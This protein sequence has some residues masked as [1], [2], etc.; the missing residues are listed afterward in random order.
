MRPPG[1]EMPSLLKGLEL[2]LKVLKEDKRLDEVGNPQVSVD[3]Y[4]K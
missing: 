3:T 4:G 1:K 2:F